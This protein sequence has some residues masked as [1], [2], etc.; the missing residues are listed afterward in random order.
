MNALIIRAAA[1]TGRKLAKDRRATDASPR[2][3]PPR[4]SIPSR[5]RRGALTVSRPLSSATLPFEGAT[6]IEARAIAR[7][8]P[9]GNAG[10][11]G[12]RSGVG[13]AKA[14]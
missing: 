5:R 8:R 11:R 1:M 6:E 13:S 7:R 2:G 10:A 9:E 4:A 14:R 3:H 12:N